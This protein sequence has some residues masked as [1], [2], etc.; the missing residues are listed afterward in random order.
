MKR[1]KKRYSFF[2]WFKLLY[3]FFPLKS[4]SLRGFCMQ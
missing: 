4:Y 2:S 3:Y 1:C